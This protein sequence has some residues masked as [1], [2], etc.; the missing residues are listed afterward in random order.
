MHGSR[1]VYILHVFLLTSE[2]LVRRRGLLAKYQW[3]LFCQPISSVFMG[4]AV[5]FTR[6]HLN[7]TLFYLSLSATWYIDI[8]GE[9]KEEGNS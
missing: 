5:V 3:N 1:C 8:S 4:M 7:L 6:G 9:T 2:A